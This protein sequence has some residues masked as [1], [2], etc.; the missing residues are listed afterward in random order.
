[1]L[2]WRAREREAACDR[3]RE[4]GSCCYVHLLSTPEG[5]KTNFS[6]IHITLQAKELW[7]LSNN[8]IAT[9]LLKSTS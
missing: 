8:H 9:L 6:D 5:L 4:R 7:R 1:M 3:E 2:G